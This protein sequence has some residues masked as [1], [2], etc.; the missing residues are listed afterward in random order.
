MKTH[1]CAVTGSWL[2]SDTLHNWE[3]LYTSLSS[4]HFP[5]NDCRLSVVRRTVM[6]TLWVTDNWL[7]S[8][9][10]HFFHAP[11]PIFCRFWS[12]LSAAVL[13]LAAFACFVVVVVVVLLY[14]VLLWSASSPNEMGRSRSPLYYYYYYD[15]EITGKY[16]TLLFPL[17]IS[18]WMGAQCLHRQLFVSG[19]E[20]PDAYSVGHRGTV[21]TID[22]NQTLP[23]WGNP[24]L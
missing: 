14:A 6:C 17:G 5:L 12:A 1:S 9:M 22:T 3:I 19:W 24:L 21:L 20:N 2:D 8:N 4:W 11:S 23:S 15:W 13:L 16:C 18:H 10:L 7:D